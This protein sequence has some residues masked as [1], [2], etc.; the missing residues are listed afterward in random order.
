MVP[1][2]AVIDFFVVCAGAG[3]KKIN[4]FWVI[5][6]P[7]LY[8][9]YAGMGYVEAWGICRGNKLSLFLP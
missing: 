8:A 3:I 7:L 6:P 1:V 9:I 2:V 4:T 5:V